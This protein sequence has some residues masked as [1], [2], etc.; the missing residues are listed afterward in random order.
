M[1]RTGSLDT[2][3]RGIQIWDQNFDKIHLKNWLP[4]GLVFREG[5]WTHGLEIN[6]QEFF[7]KTIA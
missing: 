6:L 2:F 5:V 3:L 4:I 1:K 7:D